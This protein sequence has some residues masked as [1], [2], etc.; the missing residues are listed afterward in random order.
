MDVANNNGEATPWSE[1]S[2]RWTRE[3]GQ[4]LVETT[5][6][7][8]IQR[9]TQGLPNHGAQITNSRCRPVVPE[10]FAQLITNAFQL[11]R[12][13][14]LLG[15]PCP[16]LG[17]TP[18]HVCF[19]LT[20]AAAESNASIVMLE[21]GS[22]AGPGFSEALVL[23][24]MPLHTVSESPDTQDTLRL[25]RRWALMSNDRSFRAAGHELHSG[26]RALA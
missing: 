2:W 5:P 26:A 12:R 8:T 16:F 14:F 11:T 21:E 1:F 4:C 9:E 25:G 18:P 13:L 6:V 3:L 23:E 24:Q 19:N 15:K 20:G 7:L 17:P 10:C 22:A